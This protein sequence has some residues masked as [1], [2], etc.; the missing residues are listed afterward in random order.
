MCPQASNRKGE[1]GQVERDSLEALLL[2]WSPLQQLRKSWD[3]WENWFLPF[4]VS[5]LSLKH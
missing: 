2:S 4:L 1:D 5:D 3:L